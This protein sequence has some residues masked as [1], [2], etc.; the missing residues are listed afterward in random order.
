MQKKQQQQTLALTPEWENNLTITKEMCASERTSER[1]KEGKR[2]PIG[3]AQLVSD[4]KRHSD[5]NKGKWHIKGIKRRFRSFKA[6]LV[7]SF[8]CL[9]LQGNKMIWKVYAHSMCAQTHTH[10]HTSNSIQ[11]RAREKT[12][13]QTKQSHKAQRL[14][15]NMSI[16][17]TAKN[18]C[19]RSSCL[20]DTLVEHCD[21]VRL[22]F[23]IGMTRENR[24]ENIW[25]KLKKLVQWCEKFV[26]RKEWNGK[27]RRR[28]CNVTIMMTVFCERLCTMPI[29]RCAYLHSFAFF[30]KSTRPFSLSAHTHTHTNVYVFLRWEKFFD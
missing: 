20:C 25:I 3:N 18:K 6:V 14:I 10:T 21:Q 24:C 9:L 12:R 4:G 23:R 11:H 13:K 17:C 16:L 28:S 5:V 27:R 19:K 26:I 29:V 22:R 30:R 1:V 2:M 8:Y 15:R 7:Q